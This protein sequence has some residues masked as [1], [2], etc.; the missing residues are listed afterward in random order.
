M[1]T[2]YFEFDYE[3]DLFASA[4]DIKDLKK[5]ASKIHS[6]VINYEGGEG[7]YIEVKDFILGAEVGF[8]I[9]P[10]LKTWAKGFAKVK[11]K[12]ALT[13]Y[14]GRTE[15]PEFFFPS[16]DDGSVV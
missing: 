4:S 8:T 3:I 14:L 9:E 16:P 2:L 13:H 6:V 10:S 15:N 7:I 12:A 5:E 1:A 11:P